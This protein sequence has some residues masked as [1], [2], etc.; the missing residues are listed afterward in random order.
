MLTEVPSR[1]ALLYNRS[2][3]ARAPMATFLQPAR[4]A[5]APLYGPMRRA[6]GA[7]NGAP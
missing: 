7:G 1:G 5:F 3:A 2:P 4:P 6:A